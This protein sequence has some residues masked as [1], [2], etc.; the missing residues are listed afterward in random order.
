MRWQGLCAGALA[1]IAA[2]GA[3]AHPVD[4]PNYEA[5]AKRVMEG[6]QAT[7]MVAGVMVD[8]KVVYTGTF[9]KA[10]AIAGK[11][12]TEDMLF[13]IASLSKAFTTTALA[14]LVDRKAIGWDDPVKKHIP[15][16]AM[17]DPWVSEHFTIRDL[18]THRSGLPLGAG[19]LL[20][21]P[22]GDAGVADILKAL[23]HLKPSTGFRDGYAYDNLLY[24]VAG[25]VVARASGKAYED[26]VE[27]EVLTPI[28]LTSCAVDVSRIK[29]GQTVVTGHERAA[30]AATGTPIDKRMAFKAAWA[31]AGGLNCPVGDMMTWA[32]FWLDGGV[33]ASGTRLISEAQKNELWKGVTPMGSGVVAKQGGST[34]LALYALGWV[35]RD[36][37]GTPMISHS[38]GAP[39]VTTNFILLPQKNVAVFAS[40]NDY[41]GTPGAWTRHI[42]DALVDGEQDVDV[43]GNAITAHKKDNEAAIKA[44]AD[45]VKPPAG[46][47]RP[48]LPLKAYAGTYRDPWYGPVTITERKGRLHIDMSRSTLLDGPLTHYSGETFAAIWPDKTMKADA[49]VT[50]AVEGGRVTG[51]KMKAISEI[52]DFSYDFHDLDLKRE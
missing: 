44:V 18:L 34:N 24:I 26:F 33:T 40:S 14:I 43:I 4:T 48:S 9:G 2:S 29:P 50:F 52:T 8:G 32:K 12:V 27:Q 11:P 21:W 47:A 23:P 38:G 45:A 30:G 49:F 36:L 6:L 42:A 37:E 39:G 17:W 22:D 51:I 35:V 15:E 10:D 41:M 3:L 25:E 7:G 16:F 13:P 31:A 28:G 19:D 46:A 1:A 5:E 20:I